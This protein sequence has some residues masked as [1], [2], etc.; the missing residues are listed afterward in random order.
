M[1]ETEYL[2]NVAFKQIRNRQFA[3]SNI[4]PFMKSVL[5]NFYSSEYRQASHRLIAEMKDLRF[6]EVLLPTQLEA[7]CNLFDPDVLILKQLF[8][9]ECKFPA[10]SDWSHLGILRQ[11]G[12]KASVD[13][14]ELFQIISTVRV[15][16]R[17]YQN[18][19]FADENRYLR[20]K[21]ALKYLLDNP[22]LLNAYLNARDT[23]LTVLRKQ[24]EQFC[25]LPIA[26]SP[27]SQYPSCLVWKGSQYPSF[28]ASFSIANPLILLS[29]DLTAAPGQHVPHSLIVGSE[30]VFIES[31]PRELAQQFC[32]SA[33]NVVSA[34][35]SHFKHVIENKDSIPK[36][37][38]EKI[39]IMT[40]EFLQNNIQYCNPAQ[41]SSSK[42]LWIENL[43]TFIDSG[44]AAIA[45]N[46]SFLLNLEPFIFVLPQNLRVF[47]SLFSRC[48]VPHNV[49]TEQIL[50]VLQS[51]RDSSELKEDEA[52]SKVRAVLD[53]IADNTGR[54][55]KANILVPVESDLSYP[56]LI[57]IDD[58]AYT[59]NEMLRGIARTSDEKYNLIHPKVSYLS[60]KLDLS[61]LS[62]Q[63]DITEDVFED[64]GQHE[65]L[66]TRLSNILR[67]YKDGLT[68]IKEM[69]QNADDAGATEVNILHDTR[70]H[71]SLNLVL[72]GMAESH[73]PALIVHNNS[74]FTKEDFENITKLAGATKANQPLKIGKF[75]V[76]F[77]SVYHITDVPSFVSGEWLYIFDPTLKHL[78]G[79]VQNENRPG[80]KLKFQSKFLAKSQQ[81]A[82]YQGLFG[83]DSSASYNGTIFRLPFRTHPSQ[84]SS[85][86]YNNHLI[87]M[88]KKDLESNGSK[89][90]LFL[91]NV[92]RITFSS[93]QEDRPIIKHLSIECIN[94]ETENVKVCVTQ[95]STKSTEYWLLSNQEQRLKSQDG[96]YKQAVASV[97][98]K[99]VK[100]Q[101]SF[102]CEAIEGNAFC[103]LPLS[104]PATGLPVHVTANFA[105]MSNRS[106]I[107]AGASS[108]MAS[109]EREYWNKQLMT[110][111]IA[112]AYC[113]L[114]KSL[115]AMHCLGRLLSYEFH[116]LWP[117]ASNLQMRFPWESLVS[118]LYHLVS[119]EELFFS[120]SICQW[121]Q[122]D[123]SY[124]LPSTLFKVI[125]SSSTDI[126]KAVK[127][128]KLPVVFLPLSHNSQLQKFVT[129]NILTEEKFAQLFLQ[130]IDLFSNS[131]KTRN[132]T[133]SMMLSAIGSA[134]TSKEHKL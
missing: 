22:S 98:C 57:P 33:K 124:F 37:M 76:G 34:V 63:L 26:S 94:D 113:N 36:S 13:A 101:S 60:S 108:A 61:P 89:L 1:T 52:W 40:Y 11:C 82:P 83:F 84:I 125:C 123:Q 130:N 23:L 134:S 20:L 77:C 92:K 133:L 51:V 56:Q 88:I 35:I 29:Q 5:D 66:T 6:V 106:G 39:S 79:V 41:F 2:L 109:D 47:S 4:V 65:P 75:G 42:W 18:I 100:K 105:V 121:L 90:L 8:L 28:L 43:L 67:E 104:V 111:I 72:E 38:L 54:V 15:T 112:Q 58:V 30:A 120:S 59:D 14:R 62:D 119:Q 115:Q 114:L 131:T 95:S 17:R 9:G 103:F 118:S 46:P 74:T 19:V 81:L 110:T 44:Q 55:S 3:S 25:W 32:C 78:K 126:I 96:A 68:I 45:A 70:T 64:A 80:K 132:E 27:P 102:L 24:A 86:I 71:S 122:I 127:I 7:P 53:W 91:Q 73:G 99:L 93:R 69:I 87:Q 107:W 16:L 117:L 31:V 49:T 12:L 129:V 116:M 48:G 21:A 97:A 50:S 128:M 85:T 10:S